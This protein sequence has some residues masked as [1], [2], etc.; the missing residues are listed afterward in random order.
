M[1]MRCFLLLT[2]MFGALTTFFDWP[3]RLFFR[4]SLSSVRG[5]EAR[6]QKEIGTTEYFVFEQRARSV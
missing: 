4:P 1:P 2:L 3:A 5:V 6:V